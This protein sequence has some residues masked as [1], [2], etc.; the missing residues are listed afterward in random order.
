MRD[1]RVEFVIGGAFFSS[2]PRPPPNVDKKSPPL[3]PYVNFVMRQKMI[4]IG[5]V[6]VE[7]NRDLAEPPNPYGL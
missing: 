4:K 2:A 6:E 1:E 5:Y 7:K 3:P